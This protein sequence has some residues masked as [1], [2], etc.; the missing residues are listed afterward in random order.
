MWPFLGGRIQ[1]PVH[2]NAELQIRI[3]S[4]KHR[5]KGIGPEAIRLLTDFGFRDLNLHRINLHV[6][7]NNEPAIKAY[8]KCGF[9]KEGTMRDG[10]WI[11]GQWLDVHVMALINNHE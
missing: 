2:R 4:E 1:H 3:G 6:F 7:A 10:A 11:D 5:G 9:D 8:E